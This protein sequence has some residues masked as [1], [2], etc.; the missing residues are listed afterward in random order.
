[1]MAAMMA[2]S[3]SS[4]TRVA[5]ALPAYRSHKRKATTTTTAKASSLA[6]RGGVAFPQK[7]NTL[8]APDVPTQKRKAQP[9]RHIDIG[10]SPAPCN[11]RS[12]ACWVEERTPR[13]MVMARRG[14]SVLI[15]HKPIVCTTATV[16]R[17]TG[18]VNAPKQQQEEKSGEEVVVE[19]PGASSLTTMKK[20]PAAEDPSFDVDLVNFDDGEEA[21][22]AKELGQLIENAAK[23]EETTPQQAPNTSILTDDDVYDDRP[24][25]RQWIAN[26]K[27]KMQK[28][29]EASKLR[30]EEEEE[31]RDD[32]VV[33]A[34]TTTDV[35]ASSSAP[36]FNVVDESAMIAAANFPIKSDALIDRTKEI[37]KRGVGKMADDFAEDF[38][39]V[40]PV[41]GPLAKD[42]FLKAI[43]SFDI[44]TGFPDLRSNYYHFRVDPF[45]PDRVW[46]TSRPVGTHTGK[47]AGRIDATG[48]KVICP[49][50]A[51]SMTFNR[52][53]QVK[54]LTVGVVMDRTA[55]NNTG[56]L[57]GIFA[58]FYAI[59]SPLPFPEANPWKMSKR[60]RFF[61][62]LGNVM[63]RRD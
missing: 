34:Q 46:Y 62:W 28:E 40:G 45:E 9:H 21:H 10:W 44:T 12:A 26:W 41:V 8:Q 14:G 24:D 16:V 35:V 47:F 7:K 60:Y 39:F 32:V 54:K 42:A 61:N 52:E 57:G 22:N 11:T 31:G 18:D 13:A 25:A 6:T 63:Q 4:S 19:T 17:C 1:M 27:E 49:P 59:G 48:T 33:A 50:Q 29:E 15:L 38:Q 20:P 30:T 53:G 55:E 58:F 36:E 43:N 5:A 56:A 37:L 51:M 23:V 3:S 2:S